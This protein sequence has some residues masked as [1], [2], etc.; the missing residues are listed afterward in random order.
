MYERDREMGMGIDRREREKRTAMYTVG[1][2][3]APLS[4]CE[5]DPAA[6]PSPYFRGWIFLNHKAKEVTVK[7]NLKKGRLTCLSDYSVKRNKT[8]AFQFFEARGTF[9]CASQAQVETWFKLS[10]ML[11]FGALTC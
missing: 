7:L 11:S 2:R 9:L 4:G 3:L 5:L 6:A 8:R 1:V 10:F